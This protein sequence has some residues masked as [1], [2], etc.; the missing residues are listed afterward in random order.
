MATTFAVR[1][2]VA[3]MMRGGALLAALAGVIALPACGG[4][5]P[6]TLPSRRT[7]GTPV[8]DVLEGRDGGAVPAA[9]AA[10]TAA[11]PASAPAA[12]APTPRCRPLRTDAMIGQ[13]GWTGSKRCAAGARLWADIPDVDR[14]CRGDADCA[15]LEAHTCFR[16]AVA[17]TAAARYRR[18][19]PCQNPAAGPCWLGR[20]AVACREGCCTL[21]RR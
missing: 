21:E 17:K 4:G 15:L 20:H 5:E 14:A 16:L 2:R 7:P 12:G 3:G 6:A 1:G 8:A 13:A 9:P 11:P 19:T 18:E 10:V